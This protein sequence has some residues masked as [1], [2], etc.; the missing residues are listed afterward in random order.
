M[1]IY[2]TKILWTIHHEGEFCRMAYDPEPTFSFRWNK[3]L[4]RFERE[5]TWYEA[6]LQMHCP[7]IGWIVEQKTGWVEVTEASEPEHSGLDTSGQVC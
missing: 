7:E 5:W 1:N 3:K 6:V 4:G 2:P